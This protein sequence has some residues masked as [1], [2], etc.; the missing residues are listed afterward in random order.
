[1][2]FFSRKL[3]FVGNDHVQS[4]GNAVCGQNK[5]VPPQQNTCLNIL[6]AQTE[7]HLIPSMENTAS[8]FNFTKITHVQSNSLI[9]QKVG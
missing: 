3:T 8:T 6:P 1:M 9:F 2:E 7:Q 4:S 5:W